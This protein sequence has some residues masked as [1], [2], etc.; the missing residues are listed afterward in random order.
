MRQVRL[1][2]TDL[3]VSVIAFGTWAFG[4]TGRRRS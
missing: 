1:G 3:Q 4:G 2:Q